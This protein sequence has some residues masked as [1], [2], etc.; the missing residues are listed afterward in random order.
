MSLSPRKHNRE[1]VCGKKRHT[2]LMRA[3]SYTSSS[4]IAASRR[5]FLRGAAGLVSTTSFRSILGAKGAKG[6]LG[7]A[8][9]TV[10]VTFGGGARDEE[11]FAEEG[12]ENIP[13]LLKEL[14][15]QGT[16]FTQVVNA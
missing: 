1:G 14:L 16:F 13:H 11:T 6:V 2:H 3:Q 7:P 15:P 5:D 9:K 4:S 12:Q 8:P 10:I